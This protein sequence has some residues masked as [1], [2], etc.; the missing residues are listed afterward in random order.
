MHAKYDQ[1]K[2]KTEDSAHTSPYKQSSSLVLLL[3]PHVSLQTVIITGVITLPTRL[4]TNSHHH[5]CYYSAHTS[6]YKQS[7]SLVLLLCPHISLQTVIITGVITF[8]RVLWIIF[9]GT[10]NNQLDTEADL[11]SDLDAEILF[12]FHRFAVCKTALHV[13]Y[14]CSLDMSA[15]WL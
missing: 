2:P 5:W 12:H 3:C 6:P 8:S 11:H 15:L 1:R 7:S 4:P 14:F 10:R 9:I 13:L